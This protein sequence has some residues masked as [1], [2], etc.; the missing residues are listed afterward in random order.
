MEMHQIKY[1][2]AS[3]ETMN[4][5]KAAELCNVSQ[6]ALTKAVRLLEEELGGELFDRHTRPLQ[7]SHLGRQLRS[8]FAEIWDLAHDIRARAERFSKLE[9]AIFTLAVINSINS[10]LLIKLKNHLKLYLPG[11]S[12]L[13]QHAPESQI[14]NDLREGSLQLGI[15]TDC[16]NADPRFTCDLLYKERYVISSAMSHPFA[17]RDKVAINELEGL[18]FIQR[19]HCEKNDE[20][21]KTL[22]TRGVNI[23]IQVATDQD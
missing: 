22:S 6:P 5:T 14:L 21:Q 9:D 10:D 1:F 2:L 13:L 15:V 12:V 16:F 11:V 17:D 4:F 8:K 18:P 23:D 7:L 19:I 20:I 3:C